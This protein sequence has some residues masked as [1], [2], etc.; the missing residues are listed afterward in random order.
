M[1]SIK[2]ITKFFLVPTIVGV[3]I[4][5]AGC[6]SPVSKEA[7]V[8]HSILGGVQHNKTVSITT[9]G[10]SE[11]G[12]MDVPNIS[13][14]DLADAIKESIIENKIFT[15]V[16]QNG[17]S[18]YQLNVSIINMSK[19]MFGASFTVQIEAAW[20]LID[21]KTDKV[22]MR[23]LITSSHT[24]NFTDAFAGVTRFRLAVEGAVKENIGLGLLNVSQLKLD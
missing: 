16:I 15:K 6:S 21:L 10:G 23:E 20:S 14:V 1:I 12:A 11:T 18:D 4:T 13:D 5:L 17:E 3:F 2:R 19:P 7:V 9:Q 8:V 24:A 22:V